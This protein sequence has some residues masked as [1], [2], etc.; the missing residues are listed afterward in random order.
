MAA[1]IIMI[2]LGCAFFLL[3]G[4][5]IFYLF[6]FMSEEIWKGVWISLVV[7]LIMFGLSISCIISGCFIESAI[8]IEKAGSSQHRYIDLPQ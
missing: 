4:L 1:E 7:F 8:A 6:N 2:I 3:S 5:S